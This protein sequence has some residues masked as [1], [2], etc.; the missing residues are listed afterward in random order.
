MNPSTLIASLIRRYPLISDQVNIAQVEVIL[1]ELQKTLNKN[2]GGDVVEFGCYIGTTSLFI[3]R[4]LDAHNDDRAFHVYDSFVGLP[5]KSIA[6]QSRAGD[7]FAA[8][9]LAVSKK[10]FIREFQKAHLKL[11][12]IHKG[13]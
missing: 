8:G 2:V 6:D 9:E 11:P 1:H 13:W 12:L 5:E 4:L 3:R 10:Q 7:Q